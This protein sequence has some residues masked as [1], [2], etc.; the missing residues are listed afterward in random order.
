MRNYFFENSKQSLLHL[1]EEGCVV[2]KAGI[3]DLQKLEKRKEVPANTLS[4]VAFVQDILYLRLLFQ[5]GK[6]GQH[7]LHP[8]YLVLHKNYAFISTYL[9]ICTREGPHP[10]SKE[11]HLV[12]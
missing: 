4:G 1:G 7:R 8:T 2:C 10:H 12:G 3:G 6:P 5:P 11:A 9:Y